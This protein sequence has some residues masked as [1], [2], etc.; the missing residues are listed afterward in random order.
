MA[1]RYIQ[2][3]ELPFHIDMFVDSSFIS[4]KDRKIVPCRWFGI[5]SKY[6]EMYGA[7][8]MLESGAVYRDIPI[9]ALSFVPQKHKWT[10]ADAQRW[11]CYGAEFTTYEYKL[12]RHS[13][14]RVRINGREWEGKYL[15]T[16][17]PLSDGFSRDP[18]QA[19]EFMFIQLDIGRVT[20]VPTDMVLFH[21]KSWNPGKLEWPKGLKRKNR[22]YHCE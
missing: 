6:G 13:D 7:S 1:E 2:Y 17:G 15:F 14:A 19:K 20:C 9:H 18:G 8:V 21:D 4:R 12:L 22:T 11:D 16:V 10:E 5:V 3:G